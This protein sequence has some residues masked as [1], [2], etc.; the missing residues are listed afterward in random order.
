MPPPAAIR[1]AS[2]GQDNPPEA[3]FC[4]RCG[5]A[6]TRRCPNCGATNTLAAQ[7][8][9]RCG[10][11]LAL[12]AGTERRVLSVLFA[13]LVGSTRLVLRT[14]PEP[15]RAISGHY[16]RAM[17]EEVGRVGG[18]IEKYIGDA[19]MAVF[20]LP[21]AHEDDADRAVRAAVAMQR[22]MA[23]LNE[24]RGLDLHLRVGIATGEVIADPSAVQAGQS[25]VTGEAVNLA[26]RL[27]EQAPPDAVVI[28]ERTF[29]A[30][31]LHGEFKPLPAADD[32]FAG[33][34]R[35]QVVMIAE[36][37]RAK[38]LRAPLVGRDDELQFLL[39]LY[40]RV[41]ESS[42]Q[43]IVT[44]MG[45]AGVGKSR[46]VEEFAALI[47]AE[48]APPQVLRGRCPSYGEGL[49]YWP[50]VEMVRQEC[51]I[52]DTDAPAEMLEK[53]RATAGRVVVPILGEEAADTI[54]ADLAALLGLSAGRAYETMWR[55]RLNAL[56]QVAEHPA[57]VDVP[58]AGPG[59]GPDV[60]IPSVRAFFN[61]LA[62]RAPLVLIFEDLHWAQES[63]LDLLERVA[64]A[65]P[66]VPI[67]T[68]CL[69]R[70]ELLERRATWGA[71]LPSHTSL[72]L[73]PLRQEVGRS[74]VFELLHR[75][76]LAA[77]VRE[78]ILTRAEGNPF[79]IEE[80]LRRLIEGGELVRVEGG[81]RLASPT[82]EIRIPDTIHGILASRLDLLTPVEKRVIL[83]ASVAGRV[84][85]LNALVAMDELPRDEVE[86]A[87]QRLQDRDLV[88][89]LRDGGDQRRVQQQFLP[90]PDPTPRQLALL[91]AG[92]HWQPA[93]RADLLG[94]APGSGEPRLAGEREFAFKH[95]LIREVAYSLVPKLA[96]SVRHLR[97]AEWLK[98]ATR[99]PVEEMLGVLAYH[100]EQAWRNAFD[101]GDRAEDLARRAVLTLRAAGTR[102]MHLRTLPE[103]Q[104]LYERA[105]HIVR[106]VGLTADLPLYLEL[107]VEYS[108]V[109]KW[110]PAPKTVFEATQTVLD[111]APALGRDDLVARAWLNRAYAEYDKGRLQD[112]DAALRRALEIF[113]RLGDR[114]GEAEALEVLGGVTSDLR[115]SLR[116][117]EE[118]YRRVLEVYREMGDGMG[119]A[120]TLAWLG[121]ALLD[122][123]RI[124]EAKTTLDEALRLGRAHHER[125]SE[126]KALFGLAIIAHLE[127]RAEECVALHHKVIRVVS[128]LGNPSDKAPI[129]RHLAMHYLRHGKT[130][131]AEEEI[132]KALAVR[133]QHGLTSDHPN[134]L[135]TQ[136]EV[137]LAKGELL[138]AA[139][140]AERALGLLGE[141]DNVSRPTHRATLARIRAA[142]GR[143]NEAEALFRASVADLEV[144]EYR[145]DF[146]LVLMKYG[147]ALGRREML[148]RARSEF[149][150]MGA[151]Y[152]VQAIDRTLEELPP[153]PAR[154]P[155]GA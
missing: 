40:H 107:L 109:V 116:I 138:A 122:G 70:P 25:M 94:L 86:A 49:T 44:V 4:M 127:G 81:W 52:T 88:V 7:F 82:V 8:C 118:A 142:Q 61:A 141:W 152:F 20:G 129:R 15:M 123:G 135:R 148:E 151:A 139:D 83:D 5:T 71:R 119:E 85:W 73:Q 47:R 114:R 106:H 22:R 38:R 9:V 12:A 84:F 66:D 140:L 45:A 31:R 112:A 117:A 27:Q 124:A 3:R 74:L 128:E 98:N 39:A 93:P 79:Y 67:L 42:R 30:L 26:Y 102:A 132:R 145:I 125:I 60:L 92:E 56:K 105:L 147:E 99:R 58:S 16:Y 10:A 28:D 75:E 54:T 34:P 41:V 48:S 80:I 77:E 59:R 72:Q 32:E 87:L 100:Y 78:A 17:R 46:L 136:A 2:C 113:R 63:L 62:H 110:L 13:D 69:S 115:G 133:R 55:D 150:A 97:F 19:V 108:D 103:A 76:P 18:V 65:G 50:L 37:Q 51:G 143:L 89:E 1:C 130:A 104:G 95:A 68:L 154:S 53:L 96:R 146:A 153:T 126:A 137:A 33:V 101:T 90:L 29:R 149:A 144:Q 36:G 131:E 11:P 43:H 111:Q 155:G 91:E 134:F 64:V 6:L 23:D 121:R 21:T 24:A 120:R 35:W 14:D 57:G